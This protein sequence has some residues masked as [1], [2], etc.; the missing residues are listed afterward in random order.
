MRSCFL[1]S[2]Q[3]MA[4][5]K[6]S[7]NEPWSN[8]VVLQ[9]VYQNWGRA[10]IRIHVKNKQTS[11]FAFHRNFIHGNTMFTNKP[12]SC[13]LWLCA[14]EGLGLRSQELATCGGVCRISDT[15]VEL[16]RHSRCVICGT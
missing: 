1:A 2:L 13:V 10:C 7:Q 11:L 6:E 12:S 16:P 5:I 15:R 3:L 4:T 14:D 8:E 9:L